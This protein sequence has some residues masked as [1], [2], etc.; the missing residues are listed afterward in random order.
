M[1]ACA[2]NDIEVAACW[3]DLPKEDLADPVMLAAVLPLLAQTGQ[4][5]LARRAVERLFDEQWD[6]ELARLYHLC[7][8]GND[9]RDGLARAE[10]WL[11]THPDDAG[12]LA[13]L[14]RQCVAAQI[15]G[16]A[17]SYLQ[18][19]LA[20]EPRSDVH[21]TLAGLFEKLERPDD[22]AEHYRLAAKLRAA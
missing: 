6:S 19:S 21:V 17:Q 16:K 22:A 5:A 20:R 11:V 8:Q 2:G 14:G 15:W 18:E 7:A 12:L 9:A 4:G 3:R 1:R 13:S 10:K